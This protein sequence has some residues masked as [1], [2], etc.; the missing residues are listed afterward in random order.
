MEVKSEMPTELIIAFIG[1]IGTVLGVTI[2]SILNFIKYLME[3]KK[4][5]KAKKEMAVPEVETTNSKP[6][7]NDV[8]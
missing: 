8:A 5:N 1:V 7:D 3:R 4:E 2:P 6:I